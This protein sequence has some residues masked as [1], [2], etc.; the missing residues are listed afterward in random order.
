MITLKTTEHFE[1]G[2]LALES[3]AI[4]ELEIPDELRVVPIYF[5]DFI[6][7]GMRSLKQ[8]EFQNLVK[9]QLRETEFNG[10]AYDLVILEG[11]EDIGTHFFIGLLRR[12]CMR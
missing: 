5:Q 3:Y 9:L 6:V 2:Y 8:I 10:F 11:I 1:V 4:F 7:L 12:I